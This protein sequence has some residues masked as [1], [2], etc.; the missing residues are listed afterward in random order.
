MKVGQDGLEHYEF[1]EML[2]KDFKRINQCHP[3]NQFNPQMKF[4][5]KDVLRL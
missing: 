4:G 2:P 5:M 1:I 3:T